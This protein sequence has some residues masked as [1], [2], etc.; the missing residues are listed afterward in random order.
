LHRIESF[1]QKTFQH[2]LLALRKRVEE[3]DPALLVPPC[4]LPDRS[5]IKSRTCDFF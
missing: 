1:N 4:K 2:R 3:G 5:R